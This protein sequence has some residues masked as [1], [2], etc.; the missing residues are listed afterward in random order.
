M[1]KE[2]DITDFHNYQHRMVD[3]IMETPGSGLFAEMG[4]GKTVATLTAIHRLIYEE[5][6]IINCLVVAPK[7]IVEHT[8]VEEIQTWKH[9]RHLTYSRIIGTPKQRL[10]AIRCKTDIH[11]ISRD[12]FEW[13]CVL[14]GGDHLPWDML[15]IDES[16]SFKSHKSKRFKAMRLVRQSFDKIVLLTGT[17]APNGLKDIWA[18]IFI[19]DGGKRLGKF[20]THFKAM[21]FNNVSRSHQYEKLEIKSGSVDRI[22]SAISDICISLKSEDYLT[23]PERVDNYIDIRLSD[24]L[25]K[26]YDTFKAEQ[27]LDIFGIDGEVTAANAAA[28]MN[29]LLQFGNGAVYEDVIYDLNDEGEAVAQPRVWHEIHNEKIK[30]LENIIE[31]ANGQQVLVAYS[32]KHDLY[33]IEKYLK[34]FKP[35]RITDGDSID[36]WNKGETQVLVMH[37][38]SAGHGLNLQKSG[39]HIM[40]YFGL[41]WSLELYQQSR[42]RLHRQGQKNRVFVHHLVCH[43]TIDCRVIRALD[44]KATSQEDLMQAVK[45]EINNVKNK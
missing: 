40:V 41:P 23:L 31:E 17:P 1:N 32:Y 16:S 27:I 3:H 21:Y 20:I 8:W 19:I 6:E 26:Q 22:Y 36:K 2:L 25:Q 37:P 30:A 12:N 18:Q 38:A 35:E 29:K 44:D 43:K 33:R 24:K 39:A 9:L 42:A 10:A 5:A 45:A 11:L 7:R 34:R 4:L 14:F 28:L 13:L 15:V